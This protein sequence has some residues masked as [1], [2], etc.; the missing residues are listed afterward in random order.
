MVTRE[1]GNSVYRNVA[2]ANKYHKKEFH[3]YFLFIIV[4][5]CPFRNLP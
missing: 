5:N 2:E 3:F 4:I 1:N